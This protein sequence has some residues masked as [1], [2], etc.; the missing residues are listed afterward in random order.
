MKLL[1]KI[2]NM[3]IA[4]AVALLNDPNESGNLTWGEMVQ[5]MSLVERSQRLMNG[6]GYEEVMSE[7][8]KLKTR[9]IELENTI[10]KMRSVFGGDN[11]D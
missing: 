2:E 4:E 1:A 11:Y 8:K 3:T 10:G 9:V 5:I 7:V 6:G